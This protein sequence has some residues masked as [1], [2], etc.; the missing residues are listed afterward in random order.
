M[1]HAE[2]ELSAALGGCARRM[3]VPGPG[4]TCG[5]QIGGLR[6]AAGG[7][8]RGGGWICGD[9]ICG[10]QICGGRHDGRL[11]AR[12]GQQQAQALASLFGE[13]RLLR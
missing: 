10:G 6:S 13:V 5:G 9:W 11:G 1:A 8:R 7:T 4:R 3:G 12:E 2:Q